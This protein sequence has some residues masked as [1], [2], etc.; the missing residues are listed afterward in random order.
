MPN[1]NPQAIAVAN[2]K[3]RPLADKF[4]QLY[5]LCKAL[6]KKDTA[7]S[8]GTLFPNNAE[9]LVDGSAEDGRAPITNADIFALRSVVGTFVT[10]MEQ[11]T[12]ANRNLVL[13]IAVNP[14]KY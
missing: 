4:G 5:N 10:Y 9:L 1:T 6:A 12:F 11:S 2:G 7:E 3:M 8:W 14:E 13:R